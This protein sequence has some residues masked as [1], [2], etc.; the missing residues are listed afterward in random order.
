[1][2]IYKTLKWWHTSG[3]IV[4]ILRSKPTLAWCVL[5]QYSNCFDLDQPVRSKPERQLSSHRPTSSNGPSSEAVE[6]QYPRLQSQ[7][8]SSHDD[9]LQ[10]LQD[11][12]CSWISQV[13]IYL[14]KLI[15]HLRTCIKF[16]LIKFLFAIV[17][18]AF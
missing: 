6:P 3:K 14:W 16:S 18:V 5:I 9:D 11:F 15:K 2:L 10:K 7:R 1:M 12:W 4:T 17:M 13:Q 8:A